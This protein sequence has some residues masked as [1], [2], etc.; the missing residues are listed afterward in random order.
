MNVLH[1]LTHDVHVITEPHLIQPPPPD[2]D[3]PLPEEDPPPPEEEPPDD[4]PP[5][6]EE[7]LELELL[8]DEDAIDMSVVRTA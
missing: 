4:D 1:Y 7:D 2:D 3:P 5:D 8:D 6:P